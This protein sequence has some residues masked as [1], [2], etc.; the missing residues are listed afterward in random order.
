MRR[1]VL[2]IGLLPL[3]A[4]CIA[5]V[6]APEPSQRFAI[7]QQVLRDDFEAVTP[8]W[9]AYNLQGAEVN[10]RDGAYRF[11]V[12][13]SRY[14]FGLNRAEPYANVVVESE[15]FHVSDHDTALY[16]VACRVQANGQGYYFLIEPGGNYAIQRLG[17]NQ[18]DAL[19]R[20][21]SGA[22]IRPGRQ[23]NVVRAVCIGDYLALY[24]NGEFVA[25]TRDTRYE[26]GYVGVAAA[27]PPNAADDLTASLYFDSVTAWL[28]SLR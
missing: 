17:R 27:L 1:F 5:A 2:L 11:E 14:V 4:G 9:D 15:S 18:A 23:R 16:G 12:G 7:I 21:Q 25:E 26:Q 28:A 22:P 24:V 13:L 10:I 6:P 19:V 3:L 8:D 20:W